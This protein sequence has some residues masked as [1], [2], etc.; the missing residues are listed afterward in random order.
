MVGPPTYCCMFRL[1]QIVTNINNT[2]LSILMSAY[3]AAFCI[4]D[5]GEV[6]G[7]GIMAC[8]ELMIRPTALDCTGAVSM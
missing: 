1:C 8:L 3:L 4:T 5:L 2:E 7:S 6:P